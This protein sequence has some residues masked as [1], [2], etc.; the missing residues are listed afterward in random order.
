[1]CSFYVQR[2]Y[3]LLA[4]SVELNSAQEFEK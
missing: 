2:Q 3:A 4:V 1:M